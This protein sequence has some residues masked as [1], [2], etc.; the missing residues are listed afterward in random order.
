MQKM[1]EEMYVY[2]EIGSIRLFI[3]I[4]LKG[5]DRYFGLYQAHSLPFFQAG[6]NNFIM[7][8]EP[9]SYL[10][11]AEDRLFF[12]TLSPCALSKCTKNYY[13]VC[14]SD[15]VLRK[16]GHHNC[17]IAL[18]FGNTE[19][20]IKECKRM[21]LSQYGLDLHIQ[22]YGCIVLVHQHASL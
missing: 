19:N 18:F 21:I 11:V 3:D 13:T 16:P 8:D 4:P 6:I 12:T 22:N 20:S 7:I 2:Y 14:P 17:L 1:L 15:F 9:L 10:A 5:A